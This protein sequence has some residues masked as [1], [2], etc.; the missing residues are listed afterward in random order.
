M[1]D[2]IILTE[3]VEITP[4]EK[5]QTINQKRSLLK[6][7]AAVVAG[8]AVNEFLTMPAESGDIAEASASAGDTAAGD[9]ASA[10]ETSGSFAGTDV[11]TET[12]SAGNISNPEAPAWDPSTAPVAGSDTVN[13]DMSFEQAFA[14]A[15]EKVG[16]GGIFVWHGEAYNTFY[17]E[18]TV[19]VSGEY[20]P[21]NIM[22]SDTGDT[23]YAGTIET[24]EE[25]SD[26]YETSGSGPG[27][28]MG[29]AIIAADLNA[30]DNIDAIVVDLN[31]D[32]SADMLSTDMNSD[33]VITD[34]EV[35]IIHDPESLVVPEFPS[36]GSVISVDVNDDGTD[37]IM[38]ADVNNDQMADFMGTD[39]NRDQE[40]DQ[41]EIQVLNPEAMEGLTAE[42]ETIEYTGEVA[43]DVPEDVTAEVL[44]QNDDDLSNLEDN[45]EEINDW[46]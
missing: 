40:I 35:I 21:V 22:E 34:D 1:K 9:I 15:R 12:D 39:E 14:A 37:D 31:Y 28:N 7:A 11:A 27:A 10:G 32:G 8:I 18:E 24:G 17:A 45:F 46:S 30:D 19:N 44:D 33:G 38:V 29:P 43:S 3:P 23:L 36:D 41:S 6:G 26:D 20:P 13:D 5:S 42:P 25:L 16:A 2:R 4:P